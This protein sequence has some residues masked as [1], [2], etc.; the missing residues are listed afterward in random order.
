MVPVERCESIN[1]GPQRGLATSPPEIKPS[2]W[3]RYVDD[4]FEKTPEGTTEQFTEHLNTVDPTGSIKLGWAR[5]GQ[6]EVG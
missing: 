2:L 3:F 6:G 5:I 1:S 4:I